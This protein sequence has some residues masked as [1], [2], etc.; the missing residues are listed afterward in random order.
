MKAFVLRAIAFLAIVVC[1]AGN[2]SAICDVT[3]AFYCESCAYCT[4]VWCWDGTQWVPQG[5]PSWQILEP[6]FCILGCEMT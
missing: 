1:L 3:S 4:Q 2:A 6:E 5:G